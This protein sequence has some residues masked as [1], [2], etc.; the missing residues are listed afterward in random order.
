MRLSKDGSTACRDICRRKKGGFLRS[1]GS[2][3]RVCK[4]LTMPTLSLKFAHVCAYLPSF[5]DDRAAY[6]EMLQ[7]RPSFHCSLPS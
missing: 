7:A 2:Y 6:D 1:C 3:E 4:F 5:W